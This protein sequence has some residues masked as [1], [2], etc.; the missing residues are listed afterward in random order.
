MKLWVK[1]AKAMMKIYN[2]M[3]KKPSLP[4][5]LKALKYCVEAYKY[6]SP[7]FEMVSSELV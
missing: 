4:Q 7:T 1:N 5:L 6:A 2:E 3:I